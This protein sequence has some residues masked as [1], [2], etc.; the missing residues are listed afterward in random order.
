MALIGVG[1]IGSSLALAAREKGLVKEVIGFGR[2]KERLDRAIQLKVIDRAELKL[3]Q[4]VQDADLVVLATPIGTFEPLLKEMAPALS[5]GCLVTDVGSVKGL[6]VERLE[7][8][9]PKESM[10]VGAHPIAGK[11][12]SGVEAAS[13][14]L[15][16]GARCVLTPTQQTDRS[17]MKSL[18]ELWE[19]VGATVVEMDPYMHDRFLG[20]VSHLPHMLAFALMETLTHSPLAVDGLLNFSG[21]GLRDVTRIA[22]SSPE[23]WRDIAL[24]N[25]KELVAAIDAYQNTLDQ[26]RQKIAEGDGEGLQRHFERAK[27]SREGLD[28]S[29]SRLEGT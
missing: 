12:Q 2:R 15:F 7:R 27:K 5:K 17:A 3:S 21:S 16:A 26:L 6:L 24:L 22:A 28:P 14:R 1:L 20:A 10:F 9:T 8:L 18:A 29:A 25:E 11:E 23:M 19:Q 13:A 4:S